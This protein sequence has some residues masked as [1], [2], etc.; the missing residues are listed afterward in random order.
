MSG[1]YSIEMEEIEIDESSNHRKRRRSSENSESAQ[2]LNIKIDVS[3]SV[4][5]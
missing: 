1:K 3:F 2:Y 5:F 4:D